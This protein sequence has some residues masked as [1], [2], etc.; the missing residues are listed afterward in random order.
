MMGWNVHIHV[1]FECTDN[2]LIAPIAKRHLDLMGEDTSREAR[3]YLQ[4]LSERT[5]QNP[6]PKGGLSLW[7]MVG[8]NTPVDEFCRELVPFWR[9]LLRDRG[10]DH[11]PRVVVLS[12][13]EQSQAATAHQIYF[14]EETDGLVIEK[15]GGLPFSFDQW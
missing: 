13:A 5:G 10:I 14:D 11:V 3:W 1:C 15:F 6:G 12:E 4:D 9:D 2:D 8:N 7:G